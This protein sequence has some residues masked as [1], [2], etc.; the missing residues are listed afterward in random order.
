MKWRRLLQATVCAG[1]VI[2]AHASEVT[3]EVVAT[4]LKN[5]WALAFIDQNQMLVTERPGRLRLV[6]MQGDV[7]EPISGLPPIEA[8]R[9]GGL[10]DLIVDRD[11]DSNQRLYFCY[12]APEANDVTRARNSTALASAVLSADRKSLTDVEILFRQDPAYAGG[13]HFGCRLVQREDGTLMM[14]LGDRYNLMQQ[15]QELDQHI[16]KVVRINTDGTIPEDNPFVR[17]ADVKPAIFSYGHRNIQGAIMAEDGQLWMHE[18]G[19]QGG[20]ELNLIKPGVNYGWPVITYGVNYG[21]GTIGQ[22]ITQAPGMAQP[23]T[24][25]APSIAPSGMAQ[26]TSDRYG[27]DWQGNFLL[28]S[29]KFRHLVRLVMNSDEVVGES[30][31][32]PRLGQRVRDVRQ[33]PDGLIYILTDRTDGQ[34]LRLKP[35]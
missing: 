35:Q 3:T 23:V 22:G 4:G 12:T 21:G 2:N 27:S 32:L 10:L 31:V 9:Q 5:P 28:G 6:N 7:G 16:G 11:F 25:W 8:G 17:Q 1:F 15:A 30:V 20:D 14:G 29:L 19:P 34:V 24:Y 13:L 18:H 33:G 26:I